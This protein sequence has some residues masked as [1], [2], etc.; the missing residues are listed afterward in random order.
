[1]TLHSWL[2]AKSK[3]RN[4]SSAQT[5]QKEEAI[6]ALKANQWASDWYLDET[7]EKLYRERL[8]YSDVVADYE[9][10][11]QIQGSGSRLTACT[12]I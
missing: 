7:V 8:F 4:W 9:K 3:K 12:A 5:Q 2:R 1:M 10:P 6:A 11:G